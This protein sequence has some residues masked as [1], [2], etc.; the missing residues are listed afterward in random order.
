MTEDY[1]G[2]G[3]EAE[4]RAQQ[5]PGFIV[6]PAMGSQELI[7]AGAMHRKADLPACNKL[8]FITVLDDGS[9]VLEEGQTWQRLMRWPVEP[10]I[11]EVQAFQANA[12][13]RRAV[14]WWDR[15]AAAKAKDD[16]QAVAQ[17]EEIAAGPTKRAA[18]RKALPK[19]P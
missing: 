2:L 12:R 9:E 14:E 17:R 16:A 13:A 10:S 5:D 18:P 3:D 11:A 4:R 6:R 8:L 1:L 15:L 7:T 19:P